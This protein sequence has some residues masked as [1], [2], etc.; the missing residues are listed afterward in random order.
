MA[1]R[2]GITCMHVVSSCIRLVLVNGPYTSSV[3]HRKYL[4]NRNNWDPVGHLSRLRQACIDRSALES[5]R[6]SSAHRHP[7]IW[8]DQRALSP[9]HHARLP[10]APQRAARA[11]AIPRSP[12]PPPPAYSPAYS[13]TPPTSPARPSPTKRRTPRHVQHAE[14]LSGREIEDLSRLDILSEHPV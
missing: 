3:Q 8:R 10:Q 14:R 7:L 12:P 9:A 11:P 4:S 1:N 5:A 2:V 6:R 13:T